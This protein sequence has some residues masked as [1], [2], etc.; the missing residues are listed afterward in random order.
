MI[1]QIH[2]GSGFGGLVRYANDIQKK[3]TNIIASEGV[4]LTS[5]QAMVAGFR[6]QAKVRPTL[7]KFVGHISLSF[8][9]DDRE[10][11]DDALMATISREYLRRMGI[12]DTQFVV[13]RHH[14]KA[15]PHV[16]IVYNRV[17][18]NGGS[19]STDT[20]FRKSAAVTKALT[21]EYG[22]TFGKDKKRVNRS[23]LKGREAVRY[24]IYDAAQDALR[25]CG[26]WT[27]FRLKLAGRGIGVKLVDC[28]NG[29]GKGVV[30]TEGNVSF[31]GGRIDRSLSYGNLIR[32]LTGENI[33]AGAGGQ[34]NKPSSSLISPSDDKAADH[35]ALDSVLNNQPT[36]DI[37]ASDSATDGSPID[38][39]VVENVAGA[40]AYLVQQP[41]IAPTTGG[42][43]GS[44]DRDDDEQD[45]DK[46]RTRR[47]R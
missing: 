38:T 33:T 40:V 7:K 31:A 10:R 37:A 1:A 17:D 16:H 28:P 30:F 29:L 8:S 26:T 19:L 2:S 25:G 35:A 23:R 21:R 24:R 11:L 12:V 41:D 36:A 5:D 22:L 32:R 13:F 39:T 6:L 9:P 15:H 45:N 3:D 34:A 18:N 14:D 44:S 4:S 43:G 42:G 27:A 20:N 47:R 46:R